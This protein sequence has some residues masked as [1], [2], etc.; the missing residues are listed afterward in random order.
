MTTL[1]FRINRILVIVSVLLAKPCITQ[2]LFVQCYKIINN[3]TE[4][5]T[6]MSKAVTVC[7]WNK[8]LNFRLLKGRIK[9]VFVQSV[10][11]T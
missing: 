10:E 11:K 3:Q 5:E 6:R 2:Q 8:P 9:M 4:S 7:V 1:N